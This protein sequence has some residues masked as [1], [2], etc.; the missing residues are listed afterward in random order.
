MSMAEFDCVMANQQSMK[1]TTLSSHWKEL[2]SCMS[3]FKLRY[4]QLTSRLLP[5]SPYSPHQARE[6]DMM[7]D[8][9]EEL[10]PAKGGLGHD[11][12]PDTSRQ[13]PCRSDLQV[14][15]DRLLQHTVEQ[16]LQQRCTGGKLLSVSSRTLC[17]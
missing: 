6:T 17:A 3:P 15:E 10:P 5:F 2:C 9:E 8:A 1:L 12:I 16:S 13:E 11:E 7:A 14:N 4:T